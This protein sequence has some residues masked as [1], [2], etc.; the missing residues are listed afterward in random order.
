MNNQFSVILK[1]YLIA[2][3]IAVFGIIMIVI[4]I[5]SEQDMLFMFAAVNLFI[6]GVLALLFSAGIL[7]RNLVLGIGVVCIA[8]TVFVGYKSV[9][10]IDNTIKHDIAFQKS[11]LLYQYSLTQIRDIQR[12]YRSKNGVYAP[13][14]DALVEFFENDKIQKIESLG[15]VPSRKLTLKERDALY[16]DK[17]ALDKNMTEREAALL[18]ELGNPENAADLASFKRD[19]VMILYKDEYLS[20]RSR[21]RVRKSLGLGEFDINELRYIPMTDPKEE[22]TIETRDNVVYLGDTIA[23]IHVYGKEAVSRFEEG[24]RKTVGFGNLSTNSDK[25]TWE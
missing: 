17:R 7:G 6:G 24:S 11:E 1:R 12:A 15:S 18:V 20:S 5:Q 16:T 2:A 3:I 10:A 14:F 9:Q 4:G 19:T 25:G 21:D 22:W 8:A 13:N 23:T